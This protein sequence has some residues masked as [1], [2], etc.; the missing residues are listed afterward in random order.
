MGC[1]FNIAD[2]RNTAQTINHRKRKIRALKIG[3]G[4]KHHW[5]RYGVRYRLKISINTLVGNRKLR[6][7]NTED[8]VAAEFFHFVC[9]EHGI[10]DRGCGYPSNDRNPA[11][12]G[13]DYNFDNAPALGPL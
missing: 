12:C 4:I 5:K 3:I 6:F 1:I 9:L 10:G 8:A 11:A 2:I 13:V 7:K